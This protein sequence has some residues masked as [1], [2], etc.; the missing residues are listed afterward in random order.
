[1][2]SMAISGVLFAG[3][4]RTALPQHLFSPESK[5]IVKLG[6][7][8]IGTMSAL[9]LGTIALLVRYPRVA[10]TR[11]VPAAQMSP[12]LRK[13]SQGRITPRGKYTDKATCEANGTT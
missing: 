13:P 9:L 12:A 7:G 8:L 2:N 11:S 10:S 4:L 6:T 1:M 5:G 3:V